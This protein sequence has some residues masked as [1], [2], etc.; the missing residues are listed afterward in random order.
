MALKIVRRLLYC[1]IDDSHK[2]IATNRDGGTFGFNHAPQIDPNLDVWVDSV[3]GSSGDPVEVS[4]WDC[5]LRLVRDCADVRDS[6]PSSNMETRA[7]IAETRRKNKIA[8][9]KF[10]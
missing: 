5:Q 3:D 6:L 4:N 1:S 2:Y 7:K 9:L 10:K 8:K